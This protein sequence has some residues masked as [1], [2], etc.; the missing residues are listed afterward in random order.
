MYGTQFYAEDESNDYLA[1]EI[2]HSI[3]SQ[4]PRSD[5]KVREYEIMYA[6]IEEG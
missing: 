2:A 5:D 3:E 4:N 1:E 6:L